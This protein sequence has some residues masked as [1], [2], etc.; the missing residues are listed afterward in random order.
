M[1]V[2]TD[3][4]EYILDWLKR[5]KPAFAFSLQPGLSPT[6]IQERVEDLPFS[7]PAEVY[8]LYQWRN[9]V[10]Y[11]DEDFAGFF[12]GYVFLSL[13]KALDEHSR[14]LEEAEEIA[15]NLWIDP[16]EV[17]KENWV[18]IFSDEEDYL[19]IE[20]LPEE[21]TELPIFYMSMSGECEK[22]Y[23]SLKDMMLTISECYKTGA[24]HIVDEALNV[25]EGREELIRVQYNGI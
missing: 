16:A 7:L 25:D 21:T 18:P 2:L 9:G 19:G 1:S 6:E 24:Y 12:P 15:E 13:E 11:G 17:W 14:L 20:C 8:E 4:L 22:R 23:N 5:N 10:G 3:N